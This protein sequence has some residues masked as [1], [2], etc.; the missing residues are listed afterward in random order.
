VRVRVGMGRPM[1]LL[2]EQAAPSNDAGERRWPSVA[3]IQG[4]KSATALPVDAMR[5][6]P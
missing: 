4:Q 6:K 5:S 3:E 1:T 2:G